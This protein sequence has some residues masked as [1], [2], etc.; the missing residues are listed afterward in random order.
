[1]LRSEIGKVYPIEEFLAAFDEVNK[2]GN[3]GKVLLKISK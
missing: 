2:N 1:V 3:K